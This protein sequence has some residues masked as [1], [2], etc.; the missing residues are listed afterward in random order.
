MSFEWR[1]GYVFAMWCF[2]FHIAYEDFDSIFWI[3]Q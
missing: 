2:G 3:R 1:L